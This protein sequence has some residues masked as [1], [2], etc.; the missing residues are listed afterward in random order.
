MVWN[1]DTVPNS[2]LQSPDGYG[3]KLDDDEFVP[4][5]TKQLPAPN[6]VLRL[7]VCL[8]EKYMFNKSVQLPESW[9]EMYRF[10]AV[11][12]DLRTQRMIMKGVVADCDDEDALEKM[13]LIIF[14]DE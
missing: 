3:W 11:L 14:S 4:M 10:A 9:P 6:A 1:R 7:V 2:G 12:T 8:C 13:M 5:T